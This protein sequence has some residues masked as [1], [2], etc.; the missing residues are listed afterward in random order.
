MWF[1]GCCLDIGPV[2]CAC[3][4]H[5]PPCPPFNKHR[6]V[7]WNHRA[8]NGASLP[9]KQPL[10]FE[11]QREA[12]ILLSC[13]F[14]ISL[15]SPCV[16]PCHT[17]RGATNTRGPSPPSKTH[18]LQWRQKGRQMGRKKGQFYV[19]TKKEGNW[20]VDHILVTMSLINQ[21]HNSC[22]GRRRGGWMREKKGLQHQH[23]SDGVQSVCMCVHD[24]QSDK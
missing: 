18:S 15:Y 23:S 13:Y 24:Q 21:I 9:F 3:T 4:Q 6:L 1:E 11:V 17:R 22:T 16:A 5:L 10:P 12:F 8:A 14:V 20:Q 7:L 19:W 2:T